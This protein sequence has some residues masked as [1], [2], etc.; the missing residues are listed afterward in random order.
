MKECSCMAWCEQLK[1]IEIQKTKKL[2]Y[3]LDLGKQNCKDFKKNQMKALAW[4][5]RNG[6]PTAPTLLCDLW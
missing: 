3:D 2:G 6:G 1:T 4:A 5:A